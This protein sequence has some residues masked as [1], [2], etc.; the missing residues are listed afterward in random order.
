MKTIQVNILTFEELT[1]EAKRTAINQYRVQGP[2]ASHIYDEAHDS[3][4]EF[5]KIFGT[6][7][8]NRSWLDVDTSH[9][10]D[11]V[12]ELSGVRLRT[13]ILNNFGSDIFRPKYLKHGILRKEKPTHH[14]MRKAKILNTGPNKGLYMVSYYSNI[15]TSCEC[16]LTGVCYD[17]SLLN[18]FL[19]FIAK[20]DKSTFEDLITDA[21]HELKK[22][23][24]DEEDSMNTD[25][26]IIEQIEAND[27]EFTETGERYF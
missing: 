19:K 22:D 18:P 14:R 23:L 2:D 3:V 20:P 4:K 7:E 26:Y 5:N 6:K 13:Y 1:E 27:Y 12:L 17:H 24:E 25:E 16:P 21:F 9:I 10:D 15:N 11:D 8:G